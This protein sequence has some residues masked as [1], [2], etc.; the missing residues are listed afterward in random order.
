MQV[1]F[2]STRSACDSSSHLSEITLLQLV[3]GREILD[4]ADV[5]TFHV[6][7]PRQNTQ[8]HFMVSM[9]LASVEG[10]LV[11]HSRIPGSP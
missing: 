2:E 6:S 5:A 10:N 3:T 9:E 8:V 4:K 11:L 1:S 7:I